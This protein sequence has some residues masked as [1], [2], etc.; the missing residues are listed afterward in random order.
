MPR[1]DL[2]DR[3]RALLVAGGTL[4]LGLLPARAPAQT[5][6]GK[7]KI[8]VIGSGK[9][10]STLGSLWTKAGHEVM[11][12]DRDAETAK[13][14]ASELGSRARTGTVTVGTRSPH[15]PPVSAASRLTKAVRRTSGRSC[16]SAGISSRAYVS[17]PP[18][19]PGT[20]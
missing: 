15:G 3:R 5:P 16:T 7:A 1:H 13:R 14:V 12:S 4:M 2:I 9:I 19:S 17:I 8:G 10:G 11:F 6:G 18:V 20:R